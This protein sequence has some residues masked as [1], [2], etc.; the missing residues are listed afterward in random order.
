LPL[1]SERMPFVLRRRDDPEFA[2]A[3]EGRFFW[4]SA[5]RIPWPATWNSRVRSTP[6][7]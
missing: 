6:E 7:R 1:P 3:V 5:E 4:R 2:A